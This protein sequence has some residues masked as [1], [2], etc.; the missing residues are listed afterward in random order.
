MEESVE[1]VI[2]G[3]HKKNQI[4]SDK[5][6][7]IVAYHETGHALVA[8]LQSDEVREFI[9]SNYNGSVLPMF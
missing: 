8:A 4:L 6:K 7:L 9:E 2:A 3:Y 5:E 1:V